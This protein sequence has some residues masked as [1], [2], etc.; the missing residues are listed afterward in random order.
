VFDAPVTI[1]V[2]AGFNMQTFA[3]GVAIGRRIEGA[4]LR[5][6]V[7][8]GPEL[9]VE[10]EEADGTG[11]GMGGSTNDVRVHLTAR[12]LGAHAKNPRW[13]GAL[14]V[15]ASPARIRRARQTDP[16]LPTSPA[17]SAGLGVGLLWEVQ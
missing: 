4:T 1:V 9:L 15:D 17:W 5:A 11:E 7:L 12:L 10:N 2:P 13:F 16:G 6:D 3:A 14:D 8:L